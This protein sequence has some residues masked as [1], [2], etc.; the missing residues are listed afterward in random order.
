LRVLFLAPRVP[1]PTLDRENV[2]PYHA[3]RFLS[4][5]HDVD[6]VTFGG[7]GVEWDARRRLRRFCPR[8][9]ILPMK[10]ARRV[11]PASARHV[12]TT[13]PLAIS[14]Y[15]SRDLMERLEALNETNRYDLIYVYSSSMAPYGRAFPLTPKILD[16]VEVSSL[17]WIEYG[18]R[19][20][21]PSSV[22]FRREGHRLK[23]LETQAVQDYQR[24]L[25]ASQT[26][27]EV[28][29]GLAPGTRRV[30]SLKTPA[31]PHAPLIRRAS[32]VP[33]ILFAG[34]LDHQP[35]RDAVKAF[36]RNIF[37]RIRDHYPDAV[38]RIAG[39][40]PSEDVRQLGGH[41][42]VFVD[43][44]ADDLREAYSTAWVAVVPHRVSRGVRNEILEALTFG[45]PTVV[46]REAF[47]GIDALPGTDLMVTDNDEDMIRT[48]ED[49]FVDPQARERLGFR[50]R[51]AMLNN[52][53]H[54]SIALRLEEI[55]EAAVRE[56]LM[57]TP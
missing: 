39:R 54:W 1:Y 36:A 5:R 3:I 32:G 30:V 29:R 38:L 22:V 27:A 16:L 50:A 14:R 41:P 7:R 56:N 9:Q 51:R 13:Q 37:P 31:P 55:V 46:S 40:N 19:R 34:H 25:L 26:E 15:E 28:L 44:R 23:H 47:V 20:P 2:R 21:F 33:T 49:L 4:L 42:G 10:G 8:V 17:R 11:V 12:F 57:P 35:N 45:V 43:D 48:I 18:A 24:V 6:L 52:Y 53:S